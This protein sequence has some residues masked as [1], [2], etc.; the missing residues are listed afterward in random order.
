MDLTKLNLKLRRDLLEAAALL[1]LSSIDLVRSAHALSDSGDQG[2]AA[3]LIKIS[4]SFKE[5]Q[6][7][8]TAYADEVSNG[9]IVRTALD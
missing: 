9:L 3:E 4:A 1:K 7:R 6:D 8:L 2:E 5:A